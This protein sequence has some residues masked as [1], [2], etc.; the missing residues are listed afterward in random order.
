MLVGGMSLER[1]IDA[2]SA[3]GRQRDEDDSPVT[4]I[5]P[6]ADEAAVLEAVDSTT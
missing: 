1:S 3:R 2:T 4:G 6:A 5:L